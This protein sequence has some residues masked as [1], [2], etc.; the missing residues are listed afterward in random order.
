MQKLLIFI[1][2]DSHSNI[3]YNNNTEHLLHARKRSTVPVLIHLFLMIFPFYKWEDQG[4][5]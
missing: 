5:S 2:K 1:Y 4:N 3:I